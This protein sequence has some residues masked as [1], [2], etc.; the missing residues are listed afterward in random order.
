MPVTR[1]GGWTCTRLI[2][3][4]FV[5][6]AIS[7]GGK[8]PSGIDTAQ[9]DIRWAEHIVIVYPLW[10]G[11]MP[12]LLK[13]FLEQAI[14]PDFAFERTEERWPRKLLKGRTARVVVTMG[15]PVMVYR[16]FYLA[17]SLRSL[18]RNILKFSGIA[19]VRETLF[20]GVQDADEHIRNRWIDRMTALGR[21][22][23]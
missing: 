14:R 18:E 6:S 20:G 9:K 16:W 10:L 21:A 8:P 7:R 12:A 19:P 23:T 1:Y 4:Y 17:H 3:P 2:F 22:G 13:G 11:T 5:A 15:M